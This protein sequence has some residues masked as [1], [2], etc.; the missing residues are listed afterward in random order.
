MVNI[1]YKIEYLKLAKIDIENIANYIMY[2]LQNKTASIKLTNE[3]I[4][5]IKKIA[6][7]PYANRQYLSKFNL[8]NC[9]RC[10]RVKNFLIFYTI[11]ESKKKIIIARIL[12]QRRDIN[13]LL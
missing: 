9:F 13:S 8:N 3:I 11:D 6:V 5:N 4:I 1:Q 10:K 12:Y 2:N 7:F